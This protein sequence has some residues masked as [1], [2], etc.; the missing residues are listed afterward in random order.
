MDDSAIQ[1][2]LDKA[3]RSDGTNGEGIIER[4]VKV[5]AWFYPWA[6]RDDIASQKAGRT[7][8]KDAD[9][10]ARRAQGDV[11]YMSGPVTVEMIK[12]YPQEWAA[13][14][15]A[16]SNPKVTIKALPGLKPSTLKY[17]EDAELFTIQDLAE[18]EN[19]QPELDAARALARRWLTVANSV[20]TPVVAKR[21]GRIPGSKNKPKTHVQ[22][23]KAAA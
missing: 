17:C 22:D 18:A 6:V 13:Y 23:A 15:A 12:A 16:L 8:Y 2:A 19:V 10:V 9:Y 3:G 11:D 4:K 20:E 5:V 7:I 14:Q 21:R 1:A